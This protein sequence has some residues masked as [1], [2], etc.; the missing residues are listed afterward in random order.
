LVIDAAGKLSF[1]NAE[2]AAI[3]DTSAEALL[4]REINALLP[5]L[6]LDQHTAQRLPGEVFPPLLDFEING[7]RF[8]PT[9]RAL[10]AD[11]KASAILS[12]RDVTERRR[13]EERRL[14]FYS[15]IAHDLRSPLNVI[16]LRTQVMLLRANDRADG[17]L[18]TEL[19]K[20]QGTLR[21]LSAMINDFLELASLEGAAYRL[22][23]VELDVTALIVRVIDE[24][25]PLADARAQRLLT[26]VLAEDVPKCVVGDAARLTQVFS[27]LLVNATKFTPVGGKI[28][29]HLDSTSQHVEVSIRDSGSG[30]AAEVIPTL[31]QRYKRAEHQVG[32]TGL[33]LLI[34]REIVEAHGGVVGVESIVGEGSRFWV[35]LPRH[36]GQSRESADDVA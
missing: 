36:P 9:V 22:Q 28:S 17:E 35:R 6:G 7:R 30:I 25:R 5:T 3:F 32:G 24:V 13:L 1:V 8:S 16:S 2:A 20:I 18:S 23:R 34:V 12:L 29:V 15:I 4:G 10:S 11:P 19:G 31:F 26:P 21:T 27:N 14:D 33:G